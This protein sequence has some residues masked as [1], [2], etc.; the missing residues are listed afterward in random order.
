[1]AGTPNGLG[2]E[3]TFRL[4]TKGENNKKLQ[5]FTF[6][7]YCRSMK[8]NQRALDEQLAA[9]VQKGISHEEDG[10]FVDW[11]KVLLQPQQNWYAKNCP[12]VKETVFDE[13][14]NV[15]EEKLARV[16][17]AYSRA[18]GSRVV[19]LDY[20]VG[21][22]GANTSTSGVDVD[23]LKIGGWNDDTAKQKHV[24]E[25][26]GFT[27]DENNKDKKWSGTF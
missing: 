13:T 9:I 26:Q 5:N 10:V 8:D 14:G 4:T 20:E 11:D 23:V 6:V 19:T 22:K 7:I 18:K 12:V 16:S 15:L 2:Q 1:M 17:P 3:E 27:Q 24:L 25:F 21:S